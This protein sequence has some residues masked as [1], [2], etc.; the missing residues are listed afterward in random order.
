MTKYVSLTVNDI[1]IPLDY[2]VEAF[3]D[4]TIRG[5]MS[6]LQGVGTIEVLDISIDGDAVAITAN[7]SRLA[8]NPFVN[9]IVRSTIIGMVSTLKGVSEIKK[10]G[11]LIKK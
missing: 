5:M 2:F 9:K 11:I 7:G 4:Q 1:T 3:V 6:S 10:L 8:I